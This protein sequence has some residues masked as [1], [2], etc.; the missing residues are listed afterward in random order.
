MKLL[1][2]LP[3]ERPG[4]TRGSLVIYLSGT[5][6]SAFPKVRIAA[7]LPQQGLGF[8]VVPFRLT[9]GFTGNCD[10]TPAKGQFLLELPA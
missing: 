7:G 8:T 9:R 1:L 2:H 4:Y 6:P 5:A 10:L 3:P